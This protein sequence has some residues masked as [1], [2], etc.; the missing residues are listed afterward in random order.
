MPR[1][2]WSAFIAIM[3]MGTFAMPVA[4][5]G[6]EYIVMGTSRVNIRT[7]PSMDSM[8]IGRASKGDIFKLIEK[9]GNWLEINM[10]S[11]APRYVFAASY[12]YDLT[13]EML[14]PGHRMALPEDETVRRL[15]YRRVQEARDRA[16]READE[17]VPAPLDAERNISFRRI[18]ED[19]II[20][21]IMHSNGI[22]PALFDDLAAEGE[23]NS[24]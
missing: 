22:Q 7:G 3:L 6:Q 21:E 20:F 9:K 16:K 11:G 23:R 5:R 2:Q 8:I 13:R 4:A 1:T 17:V 15:L 14:V 12:V 19:R 18:A 24:W 10:F